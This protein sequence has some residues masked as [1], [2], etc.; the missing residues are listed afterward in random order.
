M[1]RALLVGS[2]LMPILAISC[3]DVIEPESTSE[4][5][6][7][8]HAVFRFDVTDPG[9]LHNAVVTAYT[10]RRSFGSSRTLTRV[11]FVTTMVAASNDVLVENG[12][13]AAASALEVEALLRPLLELRNRGIYDIFDKDRL[14]L[15]GAIDYWE[16]IGVFSS[17]DARLFRKT[18]YNGR[19][20]PG[21]RPDLLSTQSTEVSDAYGLFEEVYRASAELWYGVGI[22]TPAFGERVTNMNRDQ[23]GIIMDALGAVIGT[24]LGGGYGGIIGGALFSVMYFQDLPPDGGGWDCSDYCNMG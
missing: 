10:A 11:E 13:P 23:D 8:S 5:V 3:G 7:F 9:A 14:D 17:A 19:A 20:E 6:P 21:F 18:L 2:L 12:L 15:V 1:L 24:F 4:A 16:S 22:P